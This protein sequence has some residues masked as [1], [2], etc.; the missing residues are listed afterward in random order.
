MIRDRDTVTIQIHT[1]DLTEENNSSNVL[2]E[3]VPVIAV[4]MPARLARAWVS[5]DQP[6]QGS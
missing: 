5:Q 2:V 3:N 6:V 4:W 1:L